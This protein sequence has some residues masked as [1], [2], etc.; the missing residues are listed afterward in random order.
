[1]HK[2]K[3]RSVPDMNFRTSQLAI[4][5]AENGGLPP[6]YDEK[7]RSVEVAAASENPVMEMDW[8]RWEMIPT[9]LRMDGIVM[10]SNGRLPLLD[11]HARFSVSTII[12]SAREFSVEDK[13]LISRIFFS[14]VE[15]AED[16]HTNVR[17]GHLT[18]VSIG[19]SAIE[20]AVF[21]EKDSRVEVGGIMYDGPVRVVTKWT[22]RELSLCPVGADELAKVRSQAQPRANNAANPNKENIV[23]NRK[24]MIALLQK[25]ADLIS[26]VDLDNASDEELTAL[27]AKATKTRS[28]PP[29]V[30]TAEPVTP[31][32][33]QVASADDLD[34][35]R[36]EAVLAERSR[37]DEI[38]AICER[39]DLPKEKRDQLLAVG[40]KDKPALIVADANRMALEHLTAKSSD[41]P[42]LPSIEMGADQ[43]DK[44]RS[45]AQ[46]SLILRIGHKCEK[47]APGS[48][49]M[50]H[51]TLRE[52]AK[53]A[54]RMA[55]LSMKG[56]PLE[57][58]GRALTTS[59]LPNILSNVANKSILVGFET[60]GETYS[61]WVDT[62]GNL[63]D[64]KQHTA[65]RASE[66]QDLDEILEDGEYQYD[67]IS[68]KKEVY[69]GATY[70]KIMRLTRKA[71]INDDLG[72]LS[73]IPFKHGEAAARKLGDLVYTVL[74]AN[75]NMGDGVA[76]FAAAHGNIGVGGAI[77]V[78]PIAD[79]LLKMKLQKDIAGVRRLNIRGEFIIGPAT[80]E[81]SAENFFNT[82][83]FGGSATKLIKNPYS[84]ERFT[85]VYE[86]RLDDTSVAVWYMAGPKG[87]HIKLFFLHGNKTPF[88][89]IK[90]GWT[91][92]GVEFKVR[93][94]AVAKA[95]DWVALLRNAGA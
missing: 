58:V 59:D 49:E 66:T 37:T 39:V 89:E 57:Y 9:V 72:E 70:G 32:A 20:E 26:G 21:V 87:K 67:K 8:E 4:R 12:G 53:E 82:A 41:V 46:D 79:A 84:G 92:D 42:F 76:L 14:T 88:T 25:R 1:M 34:K 55:N 85:R 45:A 43:K 15:A 31:P 23:M 81:G 60:A 29:V 51:F 11:C 54:L 40:T 69:T 95:M 80:I 19:R 52:M 27:V 17:E 13:K 35:I 91:I 68:D 86:A 83:Q 62:S 36:D 24:Q 7:S 22:P 65:T 44:F 61:V 56:T 71:I 2:N 38:N 93:I 50:R 18:D 10:P 3:N 5:A 90:Q 75:A 77:E 73:N 28:T 64:L 30:P 33:P 16:P 74:T 78:T 6:T 47:P 94:D 48:D 63:N